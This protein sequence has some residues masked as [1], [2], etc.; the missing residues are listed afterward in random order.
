MDNEKKICV[1]L[2]DDE[3]DFRR[4]LA[5]RLVHR[6]MEVLEAGGGQEALSILK[7]RAVT[8]IVLDVKMPGMDGIETLA[9]IRQAD[10]PVEVILLTGH[11]AMED[12]LAGIKA[13][14]FDYLTKPVNLEHLVQ[15]IR[16]AA[17]KIAAQ[18]AKVREQEFRE[19][20]EQQM[21]ATERLAALG[22]L[23]AGVAHEINNPL[24]IIGEAAGFALML[25]EKPQARQLPFYDN[26]VNALSKI[27]QNV[28]RGRTITHQLLS[29]AR[30]GN[31]AVVLKETD[32]VDII[33]DV[34]AMVGRE[35][36][37]KDVTL[38]VESKATKVYAWT[39]PDGVRQ[40]FVNLIA[41]ALAASERGQTIAVVIEE[42]E[43]M[44]KVD[45]ADTGCGIAR[46]NLDRIFEPF[47]TTKPPGS[48]TGLGLFMSRGILDRLGGS[49]E[50]KSK[51]GCGS[52][53]TVFIPKVSKNAVVRE[54]DKHWLEA[55]KEIERSNSHGSGAR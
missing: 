23:A 19:R 12:G 1:L 30:G 7:D 8:V 55:A 40:V 39:N 29:F 32:I 48:G 41:N 45:V 26:L 9:A 13:G 3:A 24:A 50:V 14:A 11:A 37:Q 6:G 10:A 43:Q 16:H 20:M 33:N 35:A 53:F 51:I 46:E 34:M 36:K 28:K 5:K 47:F 22:T 49:I 54:P 44:I 4:P 18:E 2:V 21:A 27:E 25:M 52:T 17:D 42:G 31:D 38:T 15:K